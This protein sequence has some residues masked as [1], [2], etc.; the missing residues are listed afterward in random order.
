MQKT[1]R[2]LLADAKL[3]GFLGALLAVPIASALMEYI[4]DIEK[5]KLTAIQI[6]EKQ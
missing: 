1:I 5:N 4:S 2:P 6:R 3:A